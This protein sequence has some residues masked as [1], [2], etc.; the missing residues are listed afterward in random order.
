MVVPSIFSVAFSMVKPFLSKATL[1]KISVFG[2]DKGEWSK[3]LLE[4]IDAN[5]L[6]AHYGG[7]LTDPDGNP[8]CLTLVII[9]LMNCQR[10]LIYNFLL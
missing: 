9:Y 4:Q 1:T 6:P 5:E 10:C 8:M 2:S 3:A 7:C